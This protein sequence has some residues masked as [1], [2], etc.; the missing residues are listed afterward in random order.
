M[1]PIAELSPPLSGSSRHE[2]S[3]GFEQPVLQVGAVDE[4]QRAELAGRDH[5]ARL[6]DQR[7]AAI[8]ERDRVHDAG[9]ASRRPAAP[10]VAAPSSPAACPR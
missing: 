3:V 9:V 4:M 2:K 7:V 6:L 5:L 8:V 1:S 10:R